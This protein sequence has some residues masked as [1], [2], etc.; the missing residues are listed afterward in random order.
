MIGC[1]EIPG[2]HPDVVAAGGAFGGA[3]VIEK[4]RQLEADGGTSIESRA[5]G[6]WTVVSGTPITP[7]GAFDDVVIS[8]EAITNR[9][10]ITSTT[11]AVTIKSLT[12]EVGNGADN[13]DRCRDRQLGNRLH[14]DSILAKLDD[15]VRLFPAQ[16]ANDDSRGHLGCL[17]FKPLML[18]DSSEES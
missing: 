16:D 1:D 8:G 11:V 14:A 3:E 13:E 7:L 12:F 6:N 17:I 5:A 15:S 10:S 9:P 4:V 18:L 2:L